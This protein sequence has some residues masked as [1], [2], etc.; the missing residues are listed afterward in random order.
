[1]EFCKKL[2]QLRNQKNLTQEELAQKLFISRTAVSKWESGR[3]YP[4]I[5][6]LKAISKLFS[7]TVDNLLSCDELISLAENENRN[8]TRRLRDLVFGILDCMAAL[9]FFLP[10]FGQQQ[11]NIIS[12]VSLLNLNGISSYM[13]FAYNFFTV[14]TAV[15]GIVILALQ[16]LRHK[17]WVRSKNYISLVISAFGVLMFIASNQP[18]AAVFIFFILAMKGLLLIKQ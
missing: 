6:S 10:F 1:M 5:D 9:L 12:T 13:R 8:K 3:G 14:L 11:D 2:Q 16:N 4:S 17:I 15:F 7:I 18:Y